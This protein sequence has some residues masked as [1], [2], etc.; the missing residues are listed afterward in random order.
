MTEAPPSVLVVEDDRDLAEMLAELLGEEG[1]E[2]D[3]AGDGQRGLHRA[4]TGRHD[5][6]VVDRGLPDVDGVDLLRRL[7]SQGLLAPVLVLTARG[8]VRDRVE[9]RHRPVGAQDLLQRAQPPADQVAV[10]GDV[11]LD[12]GERAPV[13]RQAQARV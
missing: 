8:T 12:V 2:V 10:G 5:L 11:A 7:R 4:L 1:Y 9:G 3:L 6:L 13:A